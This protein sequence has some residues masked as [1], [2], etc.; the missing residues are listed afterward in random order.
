MP[1]NLD[2]RFIP[3]QSNVLEDNYILVPGCKR[4]VTFVLEFR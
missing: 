4:L 1:G 3:A 2:I